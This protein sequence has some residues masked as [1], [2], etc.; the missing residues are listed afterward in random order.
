MTSDANVRAESHSAPLNWGV[1]A[2]MLLGGVSVAITLGALSP[3]LPQIDAALARTT[4]DHLLIKLLSTIVGLTMVIG[5]PLTGFLVDRVGARGVLIAGSVIFAVAGT[6]GL[7][8]DSLPA[9]IGS[10][11]FVGLGASA[12]A[13]VAMTL[14]SSR[15]DG[16]DRAKWMG[17]HVAVATLGGLL[18]NPIAGLL[19]ELSWRGPF[20]LYLLGLAIAVIAMMGVDNWR[21]APRA[22]SSAP[23]QPV[24]KWFPVRYAFLALCIGSIT[25]LP[26]VY[27]PF[28]AR[29][30]GATSPFVISLILLADTTL[31][32]IMATLFGRFRRPIPSPVA[33]AFSFACTGIGM[34]VTA[35]SPNVTFIFVGMMIFG[36]GLGWF[37]PNLM[38]AAAK[39]VAAD[40]QGRTVGLVKAAHYLAAPLSTVMVEPLTRQVGPQ[41]G[42]L[43]GA[44]LS[45]CLLILF[46]CQL[47]LRPR[48][49]APVSQKASL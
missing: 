49:G 4:D 47:A 40:Q 10:R 38:T 21:P 19:G 22:A 23:S 32:I 14:I 12:M 34:L 46:G 29:A 28:L 44:A 31:T 20:A 35:L 30:A 42:L 41:G 3:V 45:F 16:A 27:V 36:L 26:I 11:L 5:A 37:V 39:C 25:Y 24:W 48:G 13:T 18:L 1:K 6:A 9:L 8:L 7:Y 17:G 43:A 33:F 15:L 2:I